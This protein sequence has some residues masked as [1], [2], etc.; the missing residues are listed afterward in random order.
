MNETPQEFHDKIIVPGLTLLASM[1]GPANT[2]AARRMLLAIA[3]QEGGPTFA[4]HQVGGPAHGPWQFE[5]GGGVHGVMYHPATT[6]LARSLVKAC[7]L[8][9]DANMIYQALPKMDILACGLA[10]LLLW[11][12]SHPLPA[13]ETTGWRTYID[14]WRPGKPH[15]KSWPEN[16]GIASQVTGFAA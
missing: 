1:G 16:W 6:D 4:R 10:R 5:K 9:W 15:S 12:D 8:P 3:Q 14:C 7:A 13:D 11:T 2:P